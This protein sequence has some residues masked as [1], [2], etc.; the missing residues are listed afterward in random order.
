MFSL[1]LFL[2]NA[3]K[4]SNPTL[5][6]G[7]KKIRFLESSKVKD[8]GERKDLCEILQNGGVSTDYENIM[9]LPLLFSPPSSLCCTTQLHFLIAVILQRVYELISIKYK[10]LRSILSRQKC[11]WQREKIKQSILENGRDC[12]SDLKRIHISDTNFRSKAKNSVKSGEK[13]YKLF[14]SHTFSS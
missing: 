10:F 13:T 12:E 9:L 3:R 7:D 4:F 1:R 5:L 2:N 6:E 14:L 8:S 11:D